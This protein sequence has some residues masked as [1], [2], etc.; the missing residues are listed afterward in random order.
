M[1]IYDKKENS[2]DIYTLEKKEEEILKRF[3]LENY[4]IFPDCI[5]DEYYNEEEK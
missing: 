2:I 5:F 3:N 4:G 1:L